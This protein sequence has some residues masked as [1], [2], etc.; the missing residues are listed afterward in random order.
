MEKILTI[1]GMHRSGTSLT[2]SWLEQCGLI[3]K[4]NLSADTG[5]VKGHFEDTEFLA[6]QA[7]I[8]KERVG[9]S[10]GWIVNGKHNFTFDDQQIKKAKGIIEDRAGIIGTWGWKDPRTTLFLND[11]KRQAPTMKTLILWR[12]CLEVVDSL[13]RRSNKAE[14]KVFKIGFRNALA[15]WIAYNKSVLEYVQKNKED[16]I[17]VSIS[18]VL[19]HDKRLFDLIENRFQ[20]GLNYVSID[21]V[22]DNRDMQSETLKIELKRQLYAKIKGVDA[23][24]QKLKKHSINFDE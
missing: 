23:L 21:T 1:A 2:A 5:N 16:T 12:P 17:L 7:E 6:F 9:K 10:K 3:L 18:S 24:E 13:I 19:T 8:I 15:T 20:L 22:Y 4:N 14:K 11:W